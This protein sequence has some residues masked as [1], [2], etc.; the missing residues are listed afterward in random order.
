M[1]PVRG[2]AHLRRGYKIDLAVP[3]VSEVTVRLQRATQ[4]VASGI[5]G[6]WSVAAPMAKGKMH[7]LRV[8][9]RLHGFGSDLVPDSALIWGFRHLSYFR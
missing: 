7:L 2:I 1:Y 6:P 4:T 5:T 3:I 8:R 9:V